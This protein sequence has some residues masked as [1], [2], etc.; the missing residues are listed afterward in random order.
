M[1]ELVFVVECIN[2]NVSLEVWLLLVMNDYLLYNRVLGNAI[3]YTFS[4]LAVL[5]TLSI[6]MVCICMI[7]YCTCTRM[8][9]FKM[10]WGT[11]KKILRVGSLQ[12]IW[13][14]RE[15]LNYEF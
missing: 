5:I 6:Y 10:F 7:N 9:N 2:P 11:S 14:S 3:Q 1:L 8:R 4:S 13:V 12:R 15:K